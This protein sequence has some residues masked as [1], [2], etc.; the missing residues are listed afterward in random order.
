MVVNV[1]TMAG[2]PAL[3]W[4]SGETPRQWQQRVLAER[5]SREKQPTPT[6][7]AAPKQP[8]PKPADAYRQEAAKIVAELGAE[9]GEAYVAA[10][11]SYAEA[12]AAEHKKLTAERE[13][14]TAEADHIAT[15]GRKFT[16]KVYR[17]G[18]RVFG[19]HEQRSNVAE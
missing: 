11:M 12:L 5:Q 3:G 18:F 15:K 9:R 2:G 10:G 17:N 13:Q 14:L 6:A 19:R 8:A 16:G 4:Q 1:N 7:M